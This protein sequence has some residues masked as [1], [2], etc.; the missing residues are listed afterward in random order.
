MLGRLKEILDRGAASTLIR[1][2]EK[3]GAEGD[4]A[5]AEL[6]IDLAYSTFDLQYGDG[7]ELS[8]GSFP[9]SS[10]N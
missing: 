10:T 7:Q 9:V 6:L 4:T 8:R 5:A 3:V 1:L 2:G